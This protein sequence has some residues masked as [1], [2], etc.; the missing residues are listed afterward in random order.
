MNTSIREND[1]KTMQLRDQAV[2][3]AV[4]DARNAGS[5]VLSMATSQ[6]SAKLAE[7]LA[8][9]APYIIGGIAYAIWMIGN[10]FIINIL[11][12]SVIFQ[13]LMTQQQVS[14]NPNAQQVNTYHAVITEYAELYGISEYVNVIKAVMVQESGGR[15]L[16]P[17]QSSECGYN[18]LYPNSPNGI[19]DPIY[20]IE[21]GVQ[22]LAA[23]L[24]I[25]GVTSPDDTETLKLALQG[26]NFGS[27]YIGWAVDK[28]GGYSPENAVE[29]SEM[30][31]QKLGW[32]IYGDTGYAGK[33]IEHMKLFNITLL[34][35][36][37]SGFIHPCPGSS[38]TSR[39]G[40][41]TLGGV[42]RPHEGI[43]LANAEGTPLL[44]SQSGEV[45]YVRWDEGGY[46]N[47]LKIRHADGYYTLY[48]HCTKV[49]VQAGD[50]VNQGD[51]VALMGNTGHS[52]G[53]HLHFEIM[54]PDG[55][56][57]DPAPLINIVY[58]Q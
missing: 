38:F 25:A 6:L 12:A 57:I 56:P 41:R 7:Q 40:M 5:A 17:M 19:T 27:G 28:Y 24:K 45:V 43:D 49:L 13:V 58:G 55:T 44:A 36:N 35:P 46:G 37:S 53:S 48:A 9:Y 51:I 26:Y 21:C 50:M 20:S 34:L 23:C 47:Y 32:S 54:E 2:Q 30:Q 16:D 18:T 33:I 8:P 14:D 52:Y 39:F 15:G 4:E 3:T 42:T 1:S 22:Y 29:F 31:K 11:V 10:I